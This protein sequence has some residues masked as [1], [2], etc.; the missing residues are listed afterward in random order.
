MSVT[1]WI[2]TSLGLLL[3]LNPANTK[4]DLPG[5]A[6]WPASGSVPI[7]AVASSFYQSWLELLVLPLSG[8]WT[9]KISGG[10]PAA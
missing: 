7:F 6:V 9:A 3:A 10:H 1:A 2:I 5:L 8:T 4:T